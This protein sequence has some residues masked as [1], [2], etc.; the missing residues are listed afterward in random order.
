MLKKSIL[1]ER[2]SRIT[3]KNLQLLIKN[4][5]REASIP[6]EDVGFVVIDN[7]EVYLSMTALNLLVENNTSVIICNSFHLPN[8]MFLNLNGHHIQQEIFKHQL[9]A[10]LPLK[11]QLWQQ[12]VVEKIKNQGILLSQ[13]TQRRNN[14]EFLASKV[15]SGDTSNIEAIAAN[16]YWK[17]FFEED[18]KRERFGDY[19][20]NFLNYG[21]AI[22]RAATARALSG[23]GLLNT[24]GIH[25]KSKYNAFTLA[26][27]IMEPFRPLVDEAVYT[28]MQHYDEQELNTEIKSV[29]LDILT[30]TVYFKNE[31]S[32]LMVAL[33]KTASSLQQCFA[34]KR[35]KIKYPKLWN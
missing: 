1:V 32:P 17:S 14:F 31:K 6:I 33:Q 19:P 2:K 20:N 30:R 16:F 34:G 10:S 24:L 12:T 23:S 18:F 7:P 27:D 29:L 9:E 11:K 5:E 3:C 35:K 15:L 25:H 22:L 8:G 4:N 26:D 13:I 21:Y 28:I